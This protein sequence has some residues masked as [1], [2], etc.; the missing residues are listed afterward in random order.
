MWRQPYKVLIRFRVASSIP[1]WIIWK[2]VLQNL[3]FSW[4]SFVLPYWRVQLSF[5][6]LF[7]VA[8]LIGCGVEELKVALSTRK[9]RVGNDT[10]VQKLKLSQVRSVFSFSTREKHVFFISLSNKNITFNIRISFLKG[11]VV[12][13]SLIFSSN[14][15]QCY[16]L[17]L[18]DC[19]KN[20]SSKVTKLNLI[21]SQESYP[22]NLMSW[23]LTY[24]WDV[25]WFLQDDILQ[26]L[27]QDDLIFPISHVIISHFKVLFWILTI[28]EVVVHLS[29][30]QF[31]WKMQL[32]AWIS[33]LVCFTK[34]L[35]S[36]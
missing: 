31:E 17:L 32:L 13:V 18:T 30:V 15:H 33:L 36:I 28:I 12:I 9:M 35:S 34:Y 4:L 7:T 24:E 6:G 11:L 19:C 10:I 25:F 26:M 22:L 16:L 1:I 27:V 29:S 14:K 2:R 8:E 21:I 5:S 23:F 3:S 20:W